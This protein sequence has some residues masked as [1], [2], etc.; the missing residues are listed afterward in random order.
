MYLD[1]LDQIKDQAVFYQY[2]SI[3][4]GDRP[5]TLSHKIYGTT[6][7]YWTF[8]LMNEDLRVS[9]WPLSTQ[10]L[11]AVIKDNY[12]HWTIVTKD[13]ISDSLFV[14]GSSIQGSVSGASGTI[15]EV[16][17]ELNQ[18]IVDTRGYETRRTTDL[19][20]GIPSFTLQTEAETG[21]RYFDLTQIPNWQADYSVTSVATV[22]ND[23]PTANVLV[24]LSNLVSQY[25]L[26]GTKLY[27]K[28]NVTPPLTPYYIDFFYQFYTNRNFTNGEDVVL[29][30]VG[31]TAISSI[32]VLRST[33]QYNSI[34]HYENTNGDIVDID[35][36]TQSVS[37]LIPTTYY[38]RAVA[39][40]DEL[41]KI[42]I[43]KPEA[44]NQIAS[45]FRKYLR[46][47]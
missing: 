40:N 20:N 24:P 10:T 19:Q 31:P 12:P 1:L 2:H 44:I 43:I 21:F 39:R 7:Y 8:F 17:L 26:R 4:D 6:K 23:D 5:D 33:K 15:V 29:Q 45:E 13:N 14:P 30:N 32:N 11:D 16:N 35:P 41:K 22:Y 46:T 42:K 38:D 36:F 18:L 27:L 28:P 9:G 47:N 34:H 25:E 3:Y 37:G